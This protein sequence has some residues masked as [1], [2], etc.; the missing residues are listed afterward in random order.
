MF[1]YICTFLPGSLTTQLAWHWMH[2]IQ[3]HLRKVQTKGFFFFVQLFRKKKTKIWQE[4]VNLTKYF[5][6]HKFYSQLT[7]SPN[8]LAV[9]VWIP[10]ICQYWPGKWL[11]KKSSFKKHHVLQ[12]FSSRG[13]P[14]S[15]VLALKK[16]Q[17]T[18]KKKSKNLPKCWFKIQWHAVFTS[19]I[20]QQP[21]AQ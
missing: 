15:H 2:L 9:I 21:L 6:Y 19:Q 11:E 20:S 14:Q 18:K 17:K 12:S 8:I 1:T 13:V 7:G 16:K 10:S 4:T 3:N 5:E